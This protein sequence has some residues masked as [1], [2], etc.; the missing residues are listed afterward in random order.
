M[1][2]GWKNI[3][4]KI[5]GAP[6]EKSRPSDWEEMEKL[7]EGDSTLKAS[8][9]ARRTGWFAGLG[10]LGLVVLAGAI[11]F[12]WPSGEPVSGNHQN[13]G[14]K[15]AV[16][17][18]I[19]TN[20]ESFESRGSSFGRAAST[21][22]NS[23]RGSG[24]EEDAESFAVDETE[25]EKGGTGRPQSSMDIQEQQSS[26]SSGGLVSQNR[27]TETVTE[28]NPMSTSEVG[29]NL[30]ETSSDAGEDIAA[31]DQNIEENSFSE[32]PSGES[33]PELSKNEDEENFNETS[34]SF[35]EERDVFDR[36]WERTYQEIVDL[37]ELSLG[38]PLDD[39]EEL[40]ENPET[41]L[42]EST[43][44]NSSSLRATGFRISGVN[45]GGIY[46]ADFDP[47]FSA[48]GYGVDVDIQ[49][50]G[51]LLNAGLYFF[52]YPFTEKV[53][54]SIDRMKVDTSFTTRVEPR[55]KYYVDSIWVILGPGSGRYVHDTT[56]YTVY[57]T[58]IDSRIDTSVFSISYAENQ[59]VRISFVEMPVVAGYRFHFGRFA[60]DLVGGAVFTKST[61]TSSEGPEVQTSLGVDAVLRPG[62]RYYFH[63][64]L[65]G[66]SRA[67]LRYPMVSDGF[68]KQNL[69]YG[70]QLGLTVHF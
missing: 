29:V 68:R 60:A 30:N 4:K 20:G 28:E 36:N 27:S 51:F 6:V 48:F 34:E 58:L 67:A 21:E 38:N 57:D 43:S 62:I 14:E 54:Q 33:A 39:G 65:S 56:D 69:R 46:S 32:T 15:E 22:E 9:K 18:R 44:T 41:E 25:D 53:T 19:N 42:R 1:A 23:D 7:I 24:K 40:T 8:P 12:F 66:F 2:K 13:P 35:S 11:F 5:D 59:Q 70:L 50:R 55:S 52:D 61:F 37:D 47:G 3:L 26:G 10:V 17:E 45:A 64:R 63:P 49:R 16:Q 31:S